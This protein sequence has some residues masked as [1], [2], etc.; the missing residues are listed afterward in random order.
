MDIPFFIEAA[1]YIVLYLAVAL[2]TA[3]NRYF[4]MKNS[5]YTHEQS[6]A[7]GLGIFLGI[8]CPITLSFLILRF[9]LVN[10]FSVIAFL[11]K[12]GND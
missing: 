12:M 3:R 8:I 2:A 4:V 1:L 10:L 7:L 6:D 5:K 11:V 9:V